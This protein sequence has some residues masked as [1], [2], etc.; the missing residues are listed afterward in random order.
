MTKINLSPYR[1]RINQAK[2]RIFRW[3]HGKGG[4]RPPFLF[5]PSGFQAPYTRGEQ[6]ADTTKAV[7]NALQEINFQLET[8]PDTDFVPFFQLPYLGEGI[9][10][11]FFGAEQLIAEDYPPYTKGRVLSTWEDVRKLPGQI[12]PEHDGWGPRIKEAVDIFLD[13]TGGE[14]P[15]GV[16]DHQSP[17]GIATKL[18]GNETLMMGL[19]D[20]P[21]GVV[22]FLNL[23]RRAASDTI[24]AMEKWAGDPDKIIKNYRA[25]LPGCGLI[26]WDDYISVLTPEL[27]IKYCTPVNNALYDEYG[28]GHMHT[29]GP[30]FPGY[31]DA[32]L[33]QNVQTLDT[34]IL[35]GFSRRKED[36]RLLKERCNEAGMK[37]CG[38]LFISDTHFADE[39]ARRKPDRP[40]IEEMIGDGTMFWRTGGTREE[41]M[42][43]TKWVD[44]LSYC[45]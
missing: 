21:D 18:I 45:T 37:I 16:P 17:Y 30:Y 39:A 42:E 6:A 19:Y 28:P 15:V 26:L 23:C 4:E 24:K 13:A 34:A 38:P 44:S 43:L 40:F 22:D 9:I 27:H 1:D 31:I 3:H 2:E 5:T 33:Q 35:R 14:I 20:D 11:S 41:G 25:P 8:F 32:V 29:C 12:D 7:E 36:Y 10:P